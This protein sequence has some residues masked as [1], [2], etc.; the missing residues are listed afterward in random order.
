MAAYFPDAR[1]YGENGHVLPYDVRH[2]PADRAHR[3]PLPDGS[4]RLRVHAEPVMAEALVVL[5]DGDTVAMDR[6]LDGARVAVWEGV[7]PPGRRSFGYTF[8]FRTVGGEPVYL[9]PAGIANAVERLDRWT[10]DL[11]AVAPLDVPE[12]MR[13]AVMYQVFPERFASGDDSLTPD[14]AD[15]WGS[16]PH[17]LRF[18]GGDL[19]GLADRVE[20]LVRLGVDVVYLN[21]VFTSPSTHKYDTVDYYTVDPAYGGNGALARVVETLHGEGIR[22]VLDASFNH[23]HPRFFAF[24]DVVARGAASAYAGWFRVHRYPVTITVRPHRIES[25]GLDQEAAY[26]TY[27]QRL[28]TQTGIAVVEADDDGPVAEPGYEAWYGVPTM[29]RIDL[30]HSGARRYFLDVAAH[31]V[32]EYDIDGWRMDVARYVD[33]DFWPEFRR[34]VRAVKPDTF[35]MAEVIGNASPWLQGDAFDATMDYTFRQLCLDYFADRRLDSAGMLDGFARLLGWY[36]PEVTAV[37]Q[38]LLSSHDTARFLH[39]AGDDPLRLRAATVFQFTVPGAPGV[40]YGDEV[41]LTGGEEPASRNAFPWHDEAAWHGD[42]LDTVT[43]LSRL[44]REH[45]ALRHGTWRTVWSGPDAIAYLRR[46]ESAEYL[47]VV[48]RG[49]DPLEAAIPA[50]GTALEVVW[51]SGTASSRPGGTLVEGVHPGHGIVVRLRP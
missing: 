33:P 47:V 19:A 38:H 13:G 40:Y 15:P 25:A 39:L 21:P 51:G 50:E 12:W 9:V 16:E 46:L 32:R 17:W 29:P 30:R 27:V 14:G 26:A 18:Q 43:G 3:S 10:I 1:H 23:C 45:P 41:G 28:R 31:W 24:A 2:D 11:D 7:V 37:N 36:A 34:A 49:D 20:H 6:I 48:N 42:L 35:L 5:D 44:R 4:V 22:L 8:A